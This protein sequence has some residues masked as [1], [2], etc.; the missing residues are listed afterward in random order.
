MLYYFDFLYQGNHDEVVAE[1]LTVGTPLES[2][3]QVPAARL[4][5]PRGMLARWACQTG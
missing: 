5:R 1:A 3:V 4:P 2:L